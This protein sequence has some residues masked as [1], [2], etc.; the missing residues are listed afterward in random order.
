MALAIIAQDTTAIKKYYEQFGVLEI[1]DS[2]VKGVRNDSSV[3][4]LNDAI[5]IGLTNNPQL[6]S[7]GMEISAFQATALQAELYPN[8]EVGLDLE[9]FLGSKD[10]SGLG[11]SENTFYITQDFV[12]GERLSAGRDV[13]LLKSDLAAWELEKERLSLITEIRKSFTVI[14]SLKYQNKL[15]EQLLKVSLD[16]QKNLERRIEAGKVSPAEAA[17][18]SLI[19]TSLEI[20]IQN[21]E[22]QYLSEIQNLKALMGNSDVQFSSVELIYN[23]EYE[24]P[25]IIE[26]RKSIL[27][28]PDLAQFKTDLKKAETEINLQKSL[29]MPDLSLSLGYR[30]INETSDNV[31]VMGASIPINIFDNNRG[32]IQEAK[33]R[34]DQTKYKYSGLRNNYEAKLSMLLNN[35]NGLSTMI[36]KLDSE[37]LPKA[38]S[39]FEIINKGNLVGRFTVLDVLDSQRSLYELESQFVNA[40]AK[41]NR[42]VIELEALTLTKFN[43]NKKARILEDE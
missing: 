13:E 10:Y 35:I 32:N 40:V 43:Y 42:N 4:K 18:A 21:T 24:I 36:Q 38:R 33:I 14:S 7:M 9:N 27:N 25:D 12:L 17:R 5:L 41:Y 20:Q 19:S 39:A 34:A 22:M 31:M 11:G 30:R 16:F 28:I 26:L 23:L 15:N 8:P 3:L 2:L 1:P 6:K 37:S 29:A